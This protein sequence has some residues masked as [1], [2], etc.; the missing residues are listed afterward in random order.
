MHGNIS[1]F[2]SNV[3]KHGISKNSHFDVQFMPPG[4]I[5]SMDIPEI[6]N[7]RCEAAELP[8][9]QIVTADS[10]I[11]GPIYKTPYGTMV[12]EMTMTFIDTNQMKIRLFF[13]D[14]MNIIFDPNM[15]QLEYLDTFVGQA[16]VTQYDTEGD[17]NTLKPIL[18]FNL[19][20]IFPTNI[21]QLATSWSDDSP[22]K[23]AVTFFYERYVMI[24]FI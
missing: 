14:W 11:Y 13:E 5:G 19:I 3:N 22:H 9:R 21:N 1:E 15:N 24:E 23:L 10:K 6:L 18:R 20:N 4:G 17:G 16:Q 7:F 2:L 12:S 8:G